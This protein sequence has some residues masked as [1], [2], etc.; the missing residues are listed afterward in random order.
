MGLISKEEA[1]PEHKFNV[2]P[3]AS[4]THNGRTYASKAEMLYAQQL[5]VD[6]DVLGFAEQP[7]VQLG[8]DTAYRPDFVIIG[9]DPDRRGAQVAY[10]VDVKGVETPEFKKIKLLWAKYMRVPLHVIARKRGRFETVEVIARAM[11]RTQEAATQ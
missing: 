10:F 5:E 3:S 11:L 9:K 8:A 4:R 2:A 7:R 6:P 1:A